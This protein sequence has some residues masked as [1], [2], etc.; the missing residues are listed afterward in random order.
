[1]QELAPLNKDI[2]L[3]NYASPESLANIIVKVNDSLRTREDV[4]EN[5]KNLCWESEFQK[6]LF[7]LK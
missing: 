6:I 4:I 7:Y 3:F 1:M 2:N 5:S